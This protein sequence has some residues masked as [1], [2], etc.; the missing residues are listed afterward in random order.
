LPD[1]YQV[2]I[3]RQRRSLIRDG[4]LRIAMLSAHSCPVGKLGAKD[5]GGM[6]VYVLEL[7]RELGKRGH[8]VDVYTRAHDPEDKQIYELGHNVRLIH[9][10]AGRNGEMHKLAVYPHLP[11]FAGKLE[12]FR[13]R[14]RLKYD[15]VYSHYW[16]SAWVGR[17]LQGWW[18]VPHII[19]F[20]TLGAIK[21]AV[22]IGEAEPELRIETERYLVKNCHR[23]IAATGKEKEGLILHYGAL[24]ETIS[25][26]PCGVNLELF[27][28][29]DKEAARQQLGLNGNKNILFVG[30]LEPLK[31][32]DRLLM[33]MT[34]LEN[35]EGTRLL[36]IGGDGN[37]HYEIERLQRLSRELHIQDSVL[38]LGLIKQEKLPL[39]YSAADVCVVP[40]YYESFGLVTLESLAC[41][42][43]VVATDVGIAKRVIRQSETGCVVPDN[44]PH[45]L[46]QKISLL[47]S[48]PEVS[49]ESINS[50]RV[51]VS[52]FNWASI[53]EIMVKEYR[54]VLADYSARRH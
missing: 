5:T 38:F 46:A 30:R 28:P 21:N 34:Y 52:R 47:L 23:I 19:M 4:Q 22:G 17:F 42:T 13:K 49:A 9:L 44:S 31:G 18:D 27:Q 12:N 32:I 45:R 20:H 43:P 51:S 37:S 3:T 35:R 33:A 8:L 54:K 40:S 7:A 6:S 53:A 10:K 1:N 48:K 16:L 2:V 25:V 41:G 24:P 11:D 39:Y 14:N 50:M 15:L 26:I 29:V 36:V